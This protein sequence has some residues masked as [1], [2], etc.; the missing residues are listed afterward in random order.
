M[1][2]NETVARYGRLSLI[3]AAFALVSAIIVQPLLDKVW[4]TPLE[5]TQHDQTRVQ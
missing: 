4:P 1:T 2:L 5:V 3:L